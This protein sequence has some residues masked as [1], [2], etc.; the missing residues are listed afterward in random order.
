[1]STAEPGCGCCTVLAVSEDAA[2]SRGE[3]EVLSVSSLDWNQ[4]ES[5]ERWLLDAVLELE[6]VSARGLNGGLASDREMVVSRER[7]KPMAGSAE[8][9][10]RGAKGLVSA[11]ALLMPVLLDMSKTDISLLSPG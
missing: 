11:G 6:V 5:R 7:V 4:K 1:M 3:S 8:S 2:S 9:D 10:S